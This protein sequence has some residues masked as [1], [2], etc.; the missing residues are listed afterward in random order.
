MSAAMV[1]GKWADNGV[2]FCFVRITLQNVS[3]Q[4]LVWSVCC[5][6]VLPHLHV[7]LKITSYLH[8]YELDWLEKIRFY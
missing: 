2:M 3:I 7:L 6:S 8:F 4:E 1:M 5:V